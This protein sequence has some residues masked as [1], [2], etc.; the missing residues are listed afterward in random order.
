MDNA[1]LAYLFGM[2]TGK[3]TIKRDNSQTEVVI[4]IP[5]KNQIPHRMRAQNMDTLNMD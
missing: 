1:E 2:I 3:G 4:E 5:H